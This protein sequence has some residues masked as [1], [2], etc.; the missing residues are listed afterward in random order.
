VTPL[1]GHL[2]GIAGPRR[3]RGA[4][5]R[6]AT[7]IDRAMNT[8]TAPGGGPPPP[9][10]RPEARRPMTDPLWRPCSAVSSSPAAPCARR[11]APRPRGPARGQGPRAVP[12]GGGQ[13]PEQRVQPDRHQPGAGREQ[14]AAGSSVA[15]TALGAAAGALLGAAGGS[16]G[17]GAAIGAGTGLLAG[18]AVGA[19]NA[20]VSSYSLQAATTRPTP[21]AW[22]ARATKSRPRRPSPRPTLRLT[23]LPGLSVLRACLRG[24]YGGPGFFRPGIGLGLGF[25]IGFGGR[26]HYGGPRHFGGGHFGGG[27]R[28]NNFRP[29]P[30]RR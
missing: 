13:L 14:S 25:G 19:N 1:G 9:P 20:Q 15:G 12:A 26:R 8:R 7:H 30:F 29:G 24:F 6:R 11:P 18:S 27:P 10:R 21:S 28:F 2:L 23:V 4:L 5:T 16:P 22:R 17:T 3:L